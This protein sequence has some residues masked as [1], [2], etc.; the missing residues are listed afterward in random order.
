[1]F[2]SFT[3]KH[4][5]KNEDPGEAGYPLGV[6]PNPT[7]AYVLYLRQLLKIVLNA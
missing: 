1:M 6:S 4:Q 5:Q 2:A 7:T 3:G